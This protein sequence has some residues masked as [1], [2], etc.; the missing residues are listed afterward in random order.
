M[1]LKLG[2]LQKGI[3]LARQSKDKLLLKECGM[4][5]EGMKQL[6]DAAELYVQAECYEKAAAI[7]N[8]LKNW[9]K[10]GPLMD[11]ITVPKL[12]LQY[13]KAKEAEKSYAEAEAAYEK[14][15]DT[16]SVIR[17]NL[18]KLD[19][20][21]KAFAL[22]RKTKSADG[23]AVVAEYCREHGDF[24]A[25]IEF[26]LMAKRPEE[27]FQMAVSHN[28][29]DKYTKALGDDGD[30]EKYTRIALYYEERKD[31]GNAA[32]FFNM[33]GNHNKA[34]KLYL[35]C[36]EKHIY[37]A[38]GVV[39]ATLGQPGSDIL[40]STLQVF[41]IGEMD[42]KIK[43]PIYIFRLYMAIG[44]YAQAAETAVLIAA[45]DQNIGNYP[46]A[47]KILFETHQELM[48]HK[49][50]IPSDLR[51]NLLLLH[52]YI[53]VKKLVKK[54]DHAAAAR[55]LIRV[56]KSISKFPTHVVPILTS[57]VIECQRAN[58]KRS[59]YEYA[60]MLMR[61]EYRKKVDERYK[62]KIEAIVRRPPTDEPEEAASACPYCD[63]LLPE[64]LLDC[65]SCKNNIPFCATTGRHM[66]ASDWCFCPHCKFP[67]LYSQ[68][69][70]HVQSGEP[71][72]M[73]NQKVELASIEQVR[74]AKELLLQG[75]REAKEELRV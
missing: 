28:Q 56:A 57:T 36:G 39:E 67:H 52:S 75:D 43:D 34:L 18:R 73:C 41:L 72:C 13:A 5:L 40:I 11:R 53:L 9:R 38:I 30:T 74:N 3:N 31:Y 55:M 48:Q 4:I 60:S 22:V 20:A 69:L 63:F 70:E 29:M 26:L 1:T 64:T 10:A 25:A 37:D 50:P 21:A 47:H 24:Q 32:R 46:V 14:A 8:Q 44:D 15:K 61:A 45:Q 2:D 51:R 16:D 54:G 71:C 17:L 33:C 65:P 7:Y 12:H 6:S 23:A 42:G 19:N 27:A 59:S 62:R 58:L 68:L 35:Q 66:V 49:I